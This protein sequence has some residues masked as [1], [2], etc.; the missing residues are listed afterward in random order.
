MTSHSFT[1]FLS[2]SAHHFYRRTRP[3]LRHLFS[4]SS[5]AL[6]SAP[7]M[8]ESIVVLGSGIIGLST[9]YFLSLPPNHLSP[10]SSSSSPPSSLPPRPPPKDWDPPSIHLIDPSPSLFRSAAS[11]LAGGFL[12][13]DWFAPP[14]APLGAFSFDLHRRLAE[15]CKGKEKW[16]WCETEGWS[17]DRDTDTEKKGDSVAEEDEGFGEL[18]VEE[19][20][21]VQRHVTDDM[22]LNWL[23]N[24]SSRATLLAA[25]QA[26]G[27]AEE[28]ES[29]EEAG[30]H[31]K[32]V[33]AQSSAFQAITDRTSTAQ[34]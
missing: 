15:A 7:N 11:G 12:A 33:R 25:Q 27:Q 18:D 26:T 2:Q 22:D 20:G 19:G 31:P 3:L 24:G 30:S 1:L 9:A 13:K 32:W 29:L 28:P 10:S 34:V 23:M 17:L 16:G 6:A 21:E 5:P 4:T 8:P 14:V